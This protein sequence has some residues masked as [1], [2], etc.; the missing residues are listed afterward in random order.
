MLNEHPGR[1][2]HPASWVLRNSSCGRARLILAVGLWPDE[3]LSRRAH[4]GHGGQH[5]SVDCGAQAAARG[6]VLL[7]PG[8]TAREHLPRVGP[9]AEEERG[10]RERLPA[11]GVVGKRI[12]IACGG[13][14]CFFF[15]N[16]RPAVCNT[17][18][19]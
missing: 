13:C 12:K 1:V 19:V 11:K 2:A 17:S 7:C 8:G 10:W 18:D 15:S 9:W 6:A 16:E 3:E 5:S 4:D 14:V